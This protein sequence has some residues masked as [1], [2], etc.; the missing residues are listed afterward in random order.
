MSVSVIIPTYNRAHMVTHAIESV[1]RQGVADCEIIVVDDGSTD[2]TAEVLRQYGDSITYLRQKNSGAGIARNRAMALAQGD[3]LAFLDSDDM[4]MDFKLSLQIALMEKLPEIGFLCSEFVI[5][6]DDGSEI[7]QGIRTWYD[8][9][10][11]WSKVYGKTVPFSSLGV[12]APTPAQEFDIHIGRLY[13]KLLYDPFILPSSSLVRRSA[14]KDDV[15]FSET[16][17][18]YEDWEFF[19]RLSRHCDGAFMELETTINRG[20]AEPGRLTRCSQLNKAT[21]RL[22]LIDSVWKSDLS[23]MAHHGREVDILES[24]L[25]L[26]KAKQAIIESRRP[27]ARRALKQWLQ[28]PA[29]QGRGRAA[30]LRFLS[31]LPAAGFVLRLIRGSSGANI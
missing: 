22:K 30:A 24:R 18:M 15:R 28:N 12:N 21:N 9:P 13:R 6:K 29:R 17:T 8:R 31:R 23:F 1:L 5:L 4:W 14:L 11:N 25:L 19:A 20:H 16:L 7:H 3:Y 27:V 10:V 26:S 2:D